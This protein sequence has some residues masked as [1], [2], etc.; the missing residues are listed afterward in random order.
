MKNIIIVH[1]NSAVKKI[2]IQIK[3]DLTKTNFTYIQ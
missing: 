2:K 1:G 3:S